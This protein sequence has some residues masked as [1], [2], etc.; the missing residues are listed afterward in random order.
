MAGEDRPARLSSLDLLRGLVVALLVLVEW[1]LPSPAYPW[2]RHSPW[3]GIRVAD[4]VFPAFLFIVGAGMAAGAPRAW[5]RHAGRAVTLV[6]VGLLF[7]AWGDTGADLS[8]LRLPGV[9]QMIG[10]SGLLAAGVVALARRPAVVGAAAA[11]LLGAHGVLLSHAPLDCGSGRLDPGCSLP[12]AVDRRVF[13]LDHLYHQGGFGHDPE[14]LVTT[15]LGATAVV[16]LGWVAARL[17][18]DR[19]AAVI[20]LA[21][22]LAGA[23]MAALVWPPHK[24]LWTPTFSLLLVAGCTALL[25]AL[26]VAFDGR[27]RRW[28][29]PVRWT[30]TALGANALLVYVAQ[31][32]VL[33]ALEQTPS[34][35]G[36]LATALLDGVGSL[37]GVS[38]LAVAVATALAA[39]LHALDWHWRV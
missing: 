30:L 12:W 20:Q 22:A 3:D 29:Q 17:V 23:G 24:R 4:V 28:P 5:S 27:P 37:L 18:L 10:V 16:L 33:R 25:L 26:S 39:A 38:L 14:G 32:V 21:L 2:L 6:A 8:Q 19:R 9:L 15:V 36:T 35:D 7:N 34:G 11:A 31:H 1:L 13:G